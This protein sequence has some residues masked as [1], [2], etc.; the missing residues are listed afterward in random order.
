MQAACCESEGQTAQLVHLLLPYDPQLHLKTAQI[1]VHQP[2]SSR[3]NAIT[4]SEEG[5]TFWV[6][7]V[8]FIGSDSFQINN[9]LNQ[10]PGGGIVKPRA[11]EIV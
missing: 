11:L 6:R 7:R 3:Y 1:S 4:I 8:I 5:S 10:N 9:Y 2:V